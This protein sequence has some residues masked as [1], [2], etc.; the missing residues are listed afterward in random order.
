MK[1]LLVQP[2]PFEPGRLGLENI[3]WLSEPVALTS[4]AAM[5]PAHEVKLLD[6]RLEQDVV[7]NQT[8][9]QWRPD[10]VATTSMTTD[11]YQALA[12]LHIAKGTLGPG[13]FTMVGGHHPSMSPGFFED[14]V[15]D[16]MVIGE[17]EETF[18]ELI[19]HLA[20]GM[21]RQQLHKI[22]GLRFRDGDG[23]F[24]TLK[25]HQNRVLDTFP[26]PAR[27]LIP[28]R[29]RKEYFFTI[30]SPLASMATSR[31]C[32]FDCNFCSIWEFYERRTRFLSAKVIC[33]RLETM[34]ERFVFWL[35]DN[36]LSSKPRLEELC[37]EIKRRRIKKYFATQGRTDFIADHPDLMRRLRDA[38][39]M[40]VLSG[41]ESNHDDALAALRKKS[42]WDKNVRAAEIMLDLGI[43]STG[44]FMARPDFTAADFDALYATI[45]EM[46]VAIPLV[47]ILTPLPGTQ[48]YKEK[49]KELLTKDQ[50]LFD[51]LHVV[52]PTRL[53]RAEFYRKYAEWND[54]TVPAN[55]RGVWAAMKK[56]PLLF[57]Q[58]IPGAWRYYQKAINY[59]PIVRSADSHLRDE[60]GIIPAE[61]PAPAV[62]AS[63]K[64]MVG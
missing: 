37:E 24:T 64:K 44:I 60:I 54:A 21:S 5:V 31:G 19:A 33:D 46:G 56:R 63:G 20:A 53:P 8:L 57:L 51:L 62:A 12:V 26:A 59:R 3:V 17:G 41:Y 27:H 48:L 38:G 11:C 14:D 55:K 45:N 13:V 9:L 50:R 30:A 39:L 10:V 43:V 25:R 47:T 32:S 29:Y 4:L 28:K 15:V 36:F 2:A 18:E 49:E 34:P 7:L 52:T 23:W 16:A 40:M 6:M 58:S 42:T 61:A 1:I 22:P 35:D